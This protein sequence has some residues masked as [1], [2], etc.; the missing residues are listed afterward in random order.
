V[1]EIYLLCIICYVAKEG[2]EAIAIRHAMMHLQDDERLAF[3]IIFFH[4]Q[5]PLRSV[6]WIPILLFI[7][8]ELSK[9]L[10]VVNSLS[11]QI[12]EKL[13]LHLF[14]LSLG[15]VIPVIRSHELP[16]SLLHSRELKCL[17]LEVLLDLIEVKLVVHVA[18][19]K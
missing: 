10:F 12:N 3:L 8:Q 1:A 19:Y 18:P 6:Q 17:P 9:L 7:A 13:I 15:N 11:F 14:K 16:Q 5:P 4:E 2:N